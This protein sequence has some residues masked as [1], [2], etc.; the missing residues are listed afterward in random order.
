MVH[1]HVSTSSRTVPPVPDGCGRDLF[2]LLTAVGV[3]VP[4]LRFWQPT[5]VYSSVHSSTGHLLQ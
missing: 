3:C 1:E 4:R 5:T 2:S